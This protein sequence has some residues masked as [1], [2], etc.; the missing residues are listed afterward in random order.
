MNLAQITVVC[1]FVVQPCGVDYE[2]KTWVADSEADKAHKRNTVRLA[3]RKLTY[4]PDESAPQ[5]RAELTKEFMMSSGKLKV[6]ASL[7]KEVRMCRL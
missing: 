1:L 5:P 7:D 6:E 3:I 4:A 2:L